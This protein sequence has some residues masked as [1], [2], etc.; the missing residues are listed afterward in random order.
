[1]KRSRE[2]LTP[3]D[4]SVTIATMMALLVANGYSTP[5]DDGPWWQTEIQKSKK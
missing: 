5:A 1:M 3:A 2:T 4:M